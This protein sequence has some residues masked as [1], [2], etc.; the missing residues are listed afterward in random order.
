MNL[1][2][3]IRNFGRSE[4]NYADVNRSEVFKSRFDIINDAVMS[5]EWGANANYYQDG[6]DMLEEEVKASEPARPDAAV[7]LGRTL[8]PNT[9][10]IT[11]SI[12]LKPE[13]AA[14]TADQLQRKN[15]ARDQISTAFQQGPQ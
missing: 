11:G 3:D 7:G 12:D 10:T 4:E 2:P 5:L 14:E 9:D 13:E 6:P 8:V 15:D 1:I